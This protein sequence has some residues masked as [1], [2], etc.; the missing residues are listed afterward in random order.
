MET[1]ITDEVWEKMD[2]S[3]KAYESNCRQCFE[4]GVEEAKRETRKKIEDR[5]KSLEWLIQDKERIIE[6]PKVG[7]TYR[8]NCKQGIVI[9]EYAIQ[10]LKE[11]EW[12]VCDRE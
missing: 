11:L 12:E 8:Q 9:F 4:T 7:D 6:D 1:E 5:I 2:K 3:K 10:E